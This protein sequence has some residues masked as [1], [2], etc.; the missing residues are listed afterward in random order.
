MSLLRLL[1]AGVL[2]VTLTAGTQ[3]DNKEEKKDNAKLLG[4]I[5]EVV[6]AAPGT[7]PVGSLMEFG[8]EGKLKLS[9]KA[10]DQEHKLDG[11]YK[12][13]GNKVELNVKL[14]DREKKQVLTIKKISER[15]LSLEDEDSKGVE[16][17]R[18]K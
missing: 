17:K 12:V 11:T 6:K 10:K 3:A 1:L 5:W 18:K 2:A 14:G 9:V 13:E 16:L 15:D 8:K 4:G 7:L